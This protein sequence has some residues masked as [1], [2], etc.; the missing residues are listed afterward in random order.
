VSGPNAL[1]WPT[2]PFR[3]QPRLPG[4]V[5]LYADWWGRLV[6]DSAIG[7]TACAPRW[8]CARSVGALPLP[9]TPRGHRRCPTICADFAGEIREHLPTFDL[10]C[11]VYKGPSPLPFCSPNSVSHAARATKH[12]GNREE[13]P[14]PVKLG[15][16][17]AWVG[18]WSQRAL[19]S[20]EERVCG[21]C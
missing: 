15:S 5:I 16:I 7:P 17:A 3:A 10:H 21:Y 11:R 12:A 19:L 20:L 18:T 2:S 6:N 13:A 9:L 8:L 4:R 14:P 1:R